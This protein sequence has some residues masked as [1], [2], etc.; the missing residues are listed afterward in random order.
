MW[1]TSQDF[2]I[3]PWS[4]RMALGALQETEETLRVGCLKTVTQTS[5]TWNQ[6][7][8]HQEAPG[9][10]PAWNTCSGSTTVGKHLISA[11]QFS[12][13][14][15]LKLL[16]LPCQEMSQNISQCIR[17]HHKRTNKGEYWQLESLFFSFSF[18]YGF[19]NH[20]VVHHY[21]HHQNS[22]VK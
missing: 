16:K 11:Q 9:R 15:Q 17:C 3:N 22:F 7:Q 18:G 8:W 21:D 5:T 4:L 2:K 13:L 10:Q 1:K 6:Q 12:A 19:S 14:V 20:K